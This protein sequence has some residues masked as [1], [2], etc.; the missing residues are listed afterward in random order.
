MDATTAEHYSIW[1]PPLMDVTA[2]EHYSIWIQQPTEATATEYITWIQ[3]PMDIITTENSAHGK[4]SRWHYCY[5]T[6]Q[7]ISHRKMLPL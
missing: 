7:L 6:L 5:R 4:N 1:I 2:T 3:P